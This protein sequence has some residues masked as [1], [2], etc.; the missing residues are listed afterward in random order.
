MCCGCRVFQCCCGC[1]DLKTG[2]LIW[3]II[4]AVFEIIFVIG[5]VASVGSTF[6]Y[7][8]II[9]FLAD[10]G[11]AIGAYKSNTGLMLAWLVVMMI[12]IVVISILI[13]VVPIVV[14]FWIHFFIQLLNVK[15]LQVFVVGT[16]VGTSLGG[17]AGGAVATPLII[18]TILFCIFAFVLNAVYIY[19]WIV[20]NSLRKSVIEERLMILPIQQVHTE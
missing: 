2:V 3:A 20:V 8:G 13:G 4:D 12:Q 1:T 7:W 15:I 11:L 17:S 18:L 5:S 16:A 10:I 6:N 9:V 14:R 19:F